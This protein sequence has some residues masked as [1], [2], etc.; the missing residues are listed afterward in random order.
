MGDL[1]TSQTA[2]LLRIERDGPGTVSGLARAE[3]V[4]PQSMRIIV[5]ALEAA[6]YIEGRAD[7]ADGRQTI[8]SL[9]DTYRQWITSGRAVREDWL[10]RKI[11]SVLSPEEQAL[12]ASAMPV[13]ERLGED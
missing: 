2:A 5:G 8:I 1:T 3:G 10:I 13:L 9:T 11:Q 12:L 7:P 4:T 6:G